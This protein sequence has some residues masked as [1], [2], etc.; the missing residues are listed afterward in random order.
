M[1]RTFFLL[2]FLAVSAVGGWLFWHSHRGSTAHGD[3]AIERK[4]LFYQSPMHPWVKSDRPGKCTVCGMDLVP[5]Y[6]LGSAANVDDKNIVMLSPESV[7]IAG[8]ATAPAQRQPV[9]RSLRVAGM[10]DDDAT[11]HRYLAATIKGRVDKLHVNFLGA[12]VSEGEPLAEF[13]SRD[14]LAAIAE[15]NQS[16]GALRQASAFK[17]RQMGLTEQQIADLP[18]RDPKNLTVSILA[19]VNGTVVKQDVFEGKWVEE[20]ERLFEIADFR[21]MW[22][23]F[24]AYE[25]D[26][27]WLRLGQEVV[28]RTSSH[29]GMEFKA[30][31]AF[32]DPNLDEITRTTKVRVE[33]DNPL[34]EENGRMRRTFLHRLFAEGRVTL[35]APE[36]L[37]VPR[38]AV[39]WP[40]GQ[41]RVFVAAG[42]GAF[43]LQRVSVGR[44]GDELVEITSGLRE[45]DHVV[46]RGGVLLDG[47]AQ[48]LNQFEE[49]SAL[50]PPDENKAAPAANAAETC[51]VSGEKLGSMG[52]PFAFQHAGRSIQL[53][54]KACKKDFAAEP[55]KYLA[56]LP[57][58]N[59]NPN[60]A[61]P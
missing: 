40:G 1:K 51:P 34:V 52:A 25:R 28:I 29:P 18:K 26:L 6:D 23:R 7:R 50:S 54:C 41:P 22:F 5:I 15:Y 59:A 48:L 45:G 36:T 11:R 42:D 13:F 39:I 53:C 31:I 2:T 16:D 17:L 21:K 19:P 60:S 38:T 61:Q 4:P 32:I 44:E 9:A 49:P 24:E 46:V 43:R 35:E 30:P 58:L 47:Q 10:I 3:H 55:E 8:I 12:E 57:R 56:R 33:L 37:A 14:L 27:P 20:G